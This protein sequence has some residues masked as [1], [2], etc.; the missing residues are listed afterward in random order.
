MTEAEANL[1]LLKID[2]NHCY[3]C[4]CTFE[5]EHKKTKHHLIPKCLKPHRN[6]C[7]NICLPCHQRLNQTYAATEPKTK[8]RIENFMDGMKKLVEKYEKQNK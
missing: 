3:I 5:N 6:I 7:V 8:Q 4:G 1:N 2:T